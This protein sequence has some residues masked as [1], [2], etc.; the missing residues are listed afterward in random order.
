[1]RNMERSPRLANRTV[2]TFCAVL[3]FLALVPGKLAAGYVLNNAVGL[4]GQEFPYGYF[5]AN[6][7][8]YLYPKTQ[9]SIVELSL[10]DNHA[11]S[12]YN[13]LQVM[14]RKPVPAHG[15]AFQL[16]YTYS[17]SIDNASTEENGDSQNAAGEPMRTN[18]WRC[19]KAVSAFDVPQRLVAN[20]SYQL[21]FG[22]ASSLPKRLTQGWTLWGI[23]TVSSGIPFTVAV[24]FGSALYGFDAVWGGLTTR[25]FFTQTATKR[26]PGQGPEEQL[27]SN[28]VLQDSNSLIQAVNSDTNFTGQFFS[29]P[30]T[31][32]NGTTVMTVPGNLGRNTFSSPGWSNGDLSIVKDTK[33]SERTTFQFRAEFFNALNQHVFAPPNRTLGT[34]GFGIA[35]STQFDP[36]EIQFG[37]RLIF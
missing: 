26:P 2:F 11:H 15:L 16:S 33:I 4:Y 14:L 3:L 6:P 5:D 23:T 13:A 17:R 35:T 25:P 8:I 12:T 19:E 21:P 37:L 27:F 10:G 1:V 20:F 24:P 34:P 7:S 30:L 31:T 32:L 22:R 29:V 36:R 28:A 9:P 18:C